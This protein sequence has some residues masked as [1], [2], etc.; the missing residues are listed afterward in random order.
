MSNYK[1]E[2]YLKNRARML[3][4]TMEWQRRNPE[5]VKINKTKSRKKARALKPYMQPLYEAKSRASK[6]ELAFDLTE[7]WARE[8]WTGKCELTGADFDL[9]VGGKPTAF[10]VSLDRIDPNRGYTQD[11][12]RFILWSV[13]RFKSN[14]DDATIMR[15]ARLLVGVH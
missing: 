11:N 8:R 7:N 1:R 2:Y 12:C 14:Y 5:L 13:N 4:K 3:Q 9:C 10:S 15:V 6:K